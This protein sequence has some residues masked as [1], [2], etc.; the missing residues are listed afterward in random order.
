MLLLKRLNQSQHFKLLQIYFLKQR[1]EQYPE[2]RALCK[3]SFEGF[4]RFLM[5]KDNYAFTNEHAN[6]DTEVTIVS[7]SYTADIFILN[8][9]NAFG[10]VSAVTK[11]LF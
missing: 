6:H 1:H 3:L 5:E 9:R 2:M 7:V 8:Q 10:F 4:S 11:H